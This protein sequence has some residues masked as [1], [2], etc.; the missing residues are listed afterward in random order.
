MRHLLL[1]DDHPLIFD[2]LVNRLASRDS[3]IRCSYAMSGDD[4]E[5]LILKDPVDVL[6]M[7]ITLGQE[8]GFDLAAKFR[9][10]VGFT[11]FLT[12]HHSS[13]Y[14]HRASK[15]GFRGYFVK[16]DPLDLVI[17]AVSYPELKTFWA[18]E[19]QLKTLESLSRNK[20]E[21]YETL[22]LR[23]QEIFRLLAEGQSYKEIAYK[24]NIS[25][26]TAS[27]HRYNVMKKLQMKNQAEL[28]R[29]A[30]DLGIIL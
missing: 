21:P 14:L 5:L 18:E 9:D 6:L 11:F 25:S 20:E 23:E 30:L 22:S 8:S 24:L 27:A 3:L 19:N 13:S 4:A 28:V 26:K 17:A 12:M 10:Q 15:E 16:S 1:V 29:Y 2:A 7:D